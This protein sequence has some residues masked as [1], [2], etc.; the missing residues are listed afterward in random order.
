MLGRS[1]KLQLLAVFVLVAAGAWFYAKNQQEVLPPGPVEDNSSAEIPAAETPDTA[2]PPTET[3]PAPAPATVAIAGTDWE[4]ADYRGIGLPSA[5]FDLRGCFTFTG[6]LSQATMATAPKPPVGP[7]WFDCFDGPA[8]AADL[9]AGRATAI[10]AAENEMPGADRIVA[11][12]PDGR[13]FQ[14]RQPAAE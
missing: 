8:I 1:L 7:A 11:I 3:A 12:Y 14:W 2:T 13:A 5:P 6:T 10:L 9:A 4:V